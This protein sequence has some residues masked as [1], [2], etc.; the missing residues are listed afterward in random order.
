M[1]QV[2]DDIA[3]P[4]GMTVTADGPNQERGTVVRSCQLVTW[5]SLIAMM[6][7]AKSM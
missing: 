2:A 6:T 5:T 4:N 1:R 3:F 7:M